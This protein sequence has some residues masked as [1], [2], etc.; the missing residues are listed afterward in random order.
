MKEKLVKSRTP[1]LGT[2][3][4]R[5]VSRCAPPLLQGRSGRERTAALGV[6]LGGARRE[7]GGAGGPRGGHG[8]PQPHFQPPV[9]AP[10]PPSQSPVPAPPLLWHCPREPPSRSKSMPTGVPLQ[11]LY[12]WAVDTD[13]GGCAPPPHT[14]GHTAPHNRFTPAPRLRRWRSPGCLASPTRRPQSSETRGGARRAFSTRP[15]LPPPPRPRW[16]LPQGVIARR[17]CTRPHVTRGCTAPVPR[18]PAP[19]PPRAPPPPPPT[20]R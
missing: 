20:A 15:P 11:S 12:L 17:G 6:C 9:T 19:Q 18:G 14:K 2:F 3:R 13:M 8:Q 5:S 10:P 1:A 16:A 7:V 4:K